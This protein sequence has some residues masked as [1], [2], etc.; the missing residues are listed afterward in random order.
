MGTIFLTGITGLVGSAFVTTLLQEYDRKIIALVRG[1]AQQSAQ[2]RVETI[3]K[4]QCEFDGVS[5]VEEQVLKNVIV[6][7]GDVADLDVDKLIAENDLSEVDTVFHCAA[8]VNLGKDPKGQTYHTNHQGTMNMVELGKKLDVKEFHYVSTAY[9][10]GKTE[11]VAYEKEQTITEFNNA[12]EKSKCEG[13]KLV[14]NC[15]IPFTIY[16]PSIIVG[17]RS[18]GKIRKPLAFYRILEFFAKMKKHQSGKNN[19]DPCGWLEMPFRFETYPS[20][21][22]YFVPIDYVQDCIYKLFPKKV[23]NKTYHLTGNSPVSIYDIVALV[24]ET[25]RIRGVDVLE[26]I[27]NPTAEEKLMGRMV[28]DLLPYFSSKIIFDQTNIV[29]ALGEDII[30]WDFDRKNLDDMMTSFFVDFF[31]NV[32]WLQKLHASR[33]LES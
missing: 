5:G 24:S 18:D 26:K 29:E 1:N 7:D 25:L 9:T 14:R 2:E 3:I 28:G 23:E 20:E 30:A 27:E 31:P 6:I 19:V 11:G 12:Y 16:R 21:N 10:A 33:K 22:I 13:E 17:R 8:D 32:E 4:E 15:G